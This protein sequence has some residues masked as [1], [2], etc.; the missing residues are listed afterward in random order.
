MQRSMVLLTLW[1]VLF[2][3]ATPKAAIA[4][5]VPPPN[6][7]KI[8]ALFIE[9]EEYVEDSDWKKLQD[10][11]DEINK[12]HLQIH[13]LLLKALPADEREELD[14]LETAMAALRTDLQKREH[15][16][17]HSRFLEMHEAFVELLDDFDYKMPPLMFLVANDINEIKE[18]VEDNEMQE[19]ADEL[20]EVEIF[21]AQ[22]VP[23]LRER[24]LPESMITDFQTQLIRCKTAVEQNKT[25]QLQTEVGALQQLFSAQSRALSQ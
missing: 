10:W 24:K 19:A 13:P 7:M 2:A 17:V 8:F 14:K 25:N 22:V 21:Y 11:L 4:K 15:D 23:T 20:R 16:T 6:L 1:V 5:P 9:G 18:A 12:Q 3:L